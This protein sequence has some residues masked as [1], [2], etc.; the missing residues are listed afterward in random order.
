MG[1]VDAS[2]VAV[3]AAGDAEALNGV[4]TN[5][6]VRAGDR[7][8]LATS[9]RGWRAILARKLLA[10]VE[11]DNAHPGHQSAVDRDR[12]PPHTE[13]PHRHRDGA[14]DRESEA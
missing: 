13:L 7:F 1:P 6:E 4:S 8:A 9:M 12:H 14:Q 11:M 10:T 5:G 3:G 2:L